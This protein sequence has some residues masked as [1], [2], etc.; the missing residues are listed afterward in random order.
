MVIVGVQGI[1]VV[2]YQYSTRVR[3][4]IV[5]TTK[6]ILRVKPRETTKQTM[7]AVQVNP[8]QFSASIIN[9]HCVV[10][11]NLATSYAST[12]LLTATS[13]LCVLFT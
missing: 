3:W 10:L 4:H 8:T 9:I 7:V 5:V 12:R 13:Y 1:P 6:A 11:P 2:V